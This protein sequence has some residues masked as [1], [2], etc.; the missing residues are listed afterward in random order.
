MEMAGR[1]E[2]PVERLVVLIFPLARTFDVKLRPFFCYGYVKI[3][4]E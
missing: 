1:T 3:N 4:H 2:N